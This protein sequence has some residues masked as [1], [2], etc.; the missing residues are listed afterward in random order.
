MKLIYS[1]ICLQERRSPCNILNLPEIHH[2]MKTIHEFSSFERNSAKPQ[3]FEKISQFLHAIELGLNETDNKFSE[4][5]WTVN[6]AKFTMPYFSMPEFDEIH[7]IRTP[8]IDLQMANL[9]SKN[10]EKSKRRLRKLKKKLNS[11]L[12]LHL[13]NTSTLDSTFNDE[14][15]NYK[16]DEDFT[17][18][19]SWNI[20]EYASKIFKMKIELQNLQQ[21]LS[22]ISE[23]YKRFKQNKLYSIKNIIQVKDFILFEAITQQ[24]TIVFL[25][26]I[27][28]YSDAKSHFFTSLFPERIWTEKDENLIKKTISA[29][30][31]TNRKL[32]SS[33]SI[34]QVFTRLADFNHTLVASPRP[35]RSQELTIMSHVRFLN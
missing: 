14:K 6:N 21:D 4:I 33:I 20:D 34:D 25:D 18:I 13:R 9:N 1:L 32:L 22:S 24:T 23:F 17:K 15:H 31:Q 3:E 30:L 16:V 19:I 10:N 2:V 8:K 26:S 11:F 28:I 12:K 35:D 27:A 7:D 5:N 29:E